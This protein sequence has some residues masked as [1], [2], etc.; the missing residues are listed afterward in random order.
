MKKDMHL[1]PRSKEERAQN[2]KS[3]EDEKSQIKIDRFAIAKKA[4]NMEEAH[5]MVAQAQ[6]D[7]EEALKAQK[8]EKEKD[9]ELQQARDEI[10]KLQAELKQTKE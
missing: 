4:K 7:A 8:K 6:K 5:A 3:E 2:K 9:E 1:P 10:A